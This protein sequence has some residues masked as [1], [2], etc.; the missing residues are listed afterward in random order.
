VLKNL[1]NRRLPIESSLE[2]NEGNMGE[3]GKNMKGWEN[4]YRKELSWIQFRAISQE[5]KLF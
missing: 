4:H 1:K 5:E 3:R 2:G